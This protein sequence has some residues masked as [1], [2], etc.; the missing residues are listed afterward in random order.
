MPRKPLLQLCAILLLFLA[1]GPDQPHATVRRADGSS[2]RVDLEVVDTP[3]GRERGLMYRSSMPEDHGMLF[4]FPD[5]I[6]R[7]F[8]MKNTLIPLDMLFITGDGRIVGVEADAVPLTTTPRSVGKPSR[9]VIE[10]NGGWAARHGVRAG[11][12]VELRGVAGV[13]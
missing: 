11:D 6:V 2:V 13:P 10:T 1:C 5:E 7:S 9:Y 12:Q 8:W 3:A 4:V